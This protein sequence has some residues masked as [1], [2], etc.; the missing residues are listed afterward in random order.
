MRVAGFSSAVGAG[1]VSVPTTHKRLRVKP[2]P[3]PKDS[4]YCKETARERSEALVASSPEVLDLDTAEGRFV[5]LQKGVGIAAKLH[6]METEGKGYQVLFVT[7]TYAKAGAWDP[8]HLTRYMT[9]VRNHYKAKTGD[10][11]RYVW[12]A[13]IQ[14]ERQD[15]TGQAVIHYHVVF[16][17]KRGYF[18]PKADRRGWWPYGMTK[19]EKARLA[20]GSVVYLMAY[21]KKHRSKEGIPHGARV[22]GIGGLSQ[23]GRSVRRWVH[24]PRFL[25]ARYDCAAR[26]R[27]QPGGGWVDGD[28]THWPSEFAPA[29]RTG[30][31]VHLVRV[32]CYPPTDVQP[33]GP[34]SFLGAG[35]A[36]AS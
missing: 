13:E 21:I 3:A 2:G 23:A 26:L 34:Y 12:V 11:L 31:R 6:Q 20:A 17:V 33:V 29:G 5:R 32:R 1:L 27:R 18:M 7:L 30:S 8:T 24:L 10:A 36:A 14:E 19:T 16:W 15:K 28:G 35:T 22:F 25:Q 9:A 4:P